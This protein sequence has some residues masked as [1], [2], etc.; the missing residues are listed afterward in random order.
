MKLS[1]FHTT[2]YKRFGRKLPSILERA[3]TLSGFE[4]SIKGIN[5]A[6]SFGL[7][8]HMDVMHVIQLVQKCLNYHHY[9]TVF[10]NQL[11]KITSNE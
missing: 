6:N 9:T 3:I 7:D 8:F 1:A 2:L 10:S 4:K 5:N 11:L